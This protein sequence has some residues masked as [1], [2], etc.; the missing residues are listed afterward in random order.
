MTAVQDR[1]SLAD[2]AAMAAFERM[3]A[4]EA[5]MSDWSPTSEV[6]GLGEGGDDEG[7][8]QA[9]DADQEDVPVGHHGGQQSVHDVLLADDAPLDRGAQLGG[10]L[11]GTG[12]EL[13]VLVGSGGLGHGKDVWGRV[14]R[15]PRSALRVKPTTRIELPS[16]GLVCP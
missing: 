8:R 16:Q 6:E 12:Q 3:Q 10:D 14:V 2:A 4:L 11:P 9:G 7:L 1:C 5:V 15:A 13:D